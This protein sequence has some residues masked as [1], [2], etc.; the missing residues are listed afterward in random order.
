MT[1]DEEC[2]GCATYYEKNKEGY[3]NSI[4]FYSTTNSYSEVCPCSIC[5]IKPMCKKACEPYMS[6]QRKFIKE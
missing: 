1:I 3:G 5:I 4:C 2:Q 6:F